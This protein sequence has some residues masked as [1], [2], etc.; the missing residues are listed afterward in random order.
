M[1]FEQLTQQ[2]ADNA[3]RIRVLVQ[4][5]STAQAR[6]KPDPASWSILEVIN[7]LYDEERED[8]RVRLDLILHKPGQPW[9]E[10]TE[11][12]V[13]TRDYNN[14]EIKSS[15]DNFLAERQASLQ[16]LKTL[17]PPD[18][19]VVY[20]APYGPMKAGDMFAAW[21]MHDLLHLRQLVELQRA[22]T[23]HLAEPYKVDYAGPW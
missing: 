10:T 21:V 20:A 7:H 11:D 2:M 22:Y 9:P 19:E 18:W 16:W 14:R 1:D 8:F 13:H 17:S 15:L 23:L 3:A 6:W 4:G 5:V 12:W